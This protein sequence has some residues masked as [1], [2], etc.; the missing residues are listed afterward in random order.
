MSVPASPSLLNQLARVASP[1]RDNLRSAHRARSAVSV[2]DLAERRRG[3][4]L[5]ELSRRIDTRTATVAVVG[6]GY[7]GLPLLLAAARAGYPVMGVDASDE[8]IHAL[9]EG[10]SY[11]TDVSDGDIGVLGS[12]IV[13]TDSRVLANADVVILAVPTPL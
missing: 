13:S 2:T 6:L 7:V 4:D 1:P 12:A 3:A 9:G 8:K 11:V 10:R 5:D